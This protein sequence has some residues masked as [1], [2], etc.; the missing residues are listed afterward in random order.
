MSSVGGNNGGAAGSSSGDGKRK[1]SEN[2][3][4]IRQFQ[5]GVSG[6]KFEVV[7]SSFKGGMIFDM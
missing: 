7:S 4:E 5:S 3:E 1:R 6:L 2:C